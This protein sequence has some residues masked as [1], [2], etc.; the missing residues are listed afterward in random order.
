[1][2][3][4]FISNFYPPVRAGGYAQLSHEVAQGLM[5]RGH[6]VEVLTSRFQ[7]EHA[8]PDETAVHRLLCLENDLYYYRPLHFLANWKRENRENMAALERTI[9]ELQPDVVMIWGMWALSKFIATGAEQLMPARVVYYLADYWP[10]APDMHRAYWNLAAERWFMQWPKRLLRFTALR[11]L[12]SE[13][14]PA[15]QFKHVLCVSGALRD[16]LIND[17]LPIEHA[18]VVYNGI[19]LDRFLRKGIFECPTGQLKLLYAGQLVPHKG[20]HTAITAVNRLVHQ[21]GIHHVHLTVLGSGHPDYE[22]SLREQVKR[23]GLHNHVRFHEPIE[24]EQMPAFLHRFNVLV[25]PS[26]Y[27]EPLARMTQ[28]AMAAGLVVVGTTTGGT[29]ELLVDGENGLAFPAED[30]D[31]L[32]RQVAR[33]VQE[34]GLHERLAKAGCR[35]V[36]ER[37]DL[38]RTIT[39]VETYLQ[40][41]IVQAAREQQPCASYS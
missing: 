4:L 7:R 8:P 41:M 28:E 24:R 13:G 9:H 16:L 1:M 39:E 22:A 23:A 31:A 20:V 19:K 38:N 12:A 40:Q 32:A 36:V 27:E 29:K 35:T 37:F 25:F 30:G 6:Q 33:L 17:G 34:P 3:I 14:T 18:Q 15:P 26:I 2:R 11:I 21:L 5:S 10:T